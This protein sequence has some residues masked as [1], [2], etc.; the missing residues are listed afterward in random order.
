[1]LS[2]TEAVSTLCFSEDCTLVFGLGSDN[3]AGCLIVSDGAI[4]SITVTQKSFRMFHM[5][6]TLVVGS[7]RVGAP[8]KSL[9]FRVVRFSPQLMQISYYKRMGLL[10]VIDYREK[11]C[12]L[13]YSQFYRD[14][15]HLCFLQ[16]KNLSP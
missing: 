7:F 11:M 1:M 8:I 5:P 10:H 6:E 4:V 14:L 12:L 2:Q 13:F 15:I 9:T 3:V 16:N